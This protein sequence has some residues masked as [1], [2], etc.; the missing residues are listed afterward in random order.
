MTLAPTVKV[1]NAFG[2][3]ILSMVVEAVGCV[4]IEGLHTLTVTAVE[5]TQQ[6][7]SVAVTRTQYVVVTVGLMPRLVCVES[8][9]EV[10]PA[11]PRYH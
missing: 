6:P 8:G 4:V 1:A 7:V 10:S 9:F 5:S 11:F 2:L 3:A